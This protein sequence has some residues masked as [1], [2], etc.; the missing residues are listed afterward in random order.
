[1]QFFWSIFLKI[2]LKYLLFYQLFYFISFLNCSFW[3]SFYCN[4]CRFPCTTK[5]FLAFRIGQ[6]FGNFSYIC[7][8]IFSKRQKSI[9]F[10]IYYVFS[11]NW[12]TYLFYLI[13]KVKFI[14]RSI[15]NG[16]LFWSVNHTSA[17]WHSE[18]NVF[19]KMW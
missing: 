13:T 7:T 3:S 10:Q 2:F 17:A 16:W 9:N 4:C 5:K 6:V 11:F 14:L 18:F 12:I 8:N 15:S 19:K 1:M